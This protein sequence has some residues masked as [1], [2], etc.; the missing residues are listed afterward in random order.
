MGKQGHLKLF[1]SIHCHVLS[2]RTSFALLR[3]PVRKSRHNATV[4]TTTSTAWFSFNTA[5][6]SASFMAVFYFERV[7]CV[8]ILITSI[9]CRMQLDAVGCSPEGKLV[10]VGTVSLL[11]VQY[12]HISFYDWYSH[13]YELVHLHVVQDCFTGV[14]AEMVLFPKTFHH[15]NAY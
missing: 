13:L 7:S 14:A 11:I 8:I 12:S 9:H 4:H 10:T 6:I 3:F 15:P 1:A 2:Q 5:H